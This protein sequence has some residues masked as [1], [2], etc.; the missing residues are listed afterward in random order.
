MY[1]RIRNNLTASI[2][3]S[4]GCQS[5]FFPAKRHL[6]VCESISCVWHRF[7]DGSKSKAHLESPRPL[8]WRSV[9][10]GPTLPYPSPKQPEG[11]LAVP[12]PCRGTQD[13]WQEQEELQLL[14]NSTGY[15]T[16]SSYIDGPNSEVAAFNPWCF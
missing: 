14:T 9:E 12:C 6:S 3:F 7:A 13:P 10:D 15:L 16:N 11:C 8:C 1:F 4:L 5:A 2:R